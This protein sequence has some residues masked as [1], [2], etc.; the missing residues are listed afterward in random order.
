MVKRNIVLLII[1]I[2]PILVYSQN[3]QAKLYKE[4]DEFTNDRCFYSLTDNHHIVLMAKKD[5]SISIWENKR[6][7]DGFGSYYKEYG[8]WMFEDSS[9]NTFDFQY[10][11]GK[12]DFSWEK[13]QEKSYSMVLYEIG[14]EKNTQYLKEKWLSNVN[15]QLFL[16]NKNA[17]VL[18]DKAYYL[19]ELG[20]HKEA[21]FI[22]HFILSY[23]SNRTVAY[24]NLGDAYWGL[25]DKENAKHAY[26][27]YI[28]LMK[29]SGKKSKILQRVLDR[30]SE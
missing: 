28:E 7:I 3:N 4:N 19:D 6:L 18:N 24:I 22:L 2:L 27:K 1:L 21:I 29:A 9:S 5:W 14:D 13:M 23:K 20:F 10:S 15:D 30:A 11:N 12:V 26:Q 17:Q 16:N 25:E 8:Y